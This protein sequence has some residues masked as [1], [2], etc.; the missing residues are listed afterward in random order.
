MK[1]PLSRLA[2]G[3]NKRKGKNKYLGFSIGKQRRIQKLYALIGCLKTISAV[4]AK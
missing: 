3:T 2:T 4:L 1:V